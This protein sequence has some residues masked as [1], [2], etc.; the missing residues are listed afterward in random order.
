MKEMV[1]GWLEGRQD[2]EQR[3]GYEGKRMEC[4]FRSQKKDDVPTSLSY[5]Y[6]F[7]IFSLVPAFITATCVSTRW[8]KCPNSLLYS[9]RDCTALPCQ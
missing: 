4:L 8:Q 2:G 6:K 9:M 3:E 5:P 1:A 7:A